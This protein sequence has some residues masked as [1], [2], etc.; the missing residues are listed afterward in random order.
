[1]HNNVP[2]SSSNKRGHIDLLGPVAIGRNFHAN[3]K[4]VFVTPFFGIGKKICFVHALVLTLL[5]VSADQ[6]N[7]LKLSI[8]LPDYYPIRPTDLQ[9]TIGLINFTTV[10]EMKIFQC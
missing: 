9:S 4:K 3:V 2:P 10:E 5:P 7:N 1:M 6:N 8:K